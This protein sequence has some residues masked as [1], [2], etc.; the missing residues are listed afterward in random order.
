MQD[1]LAQVYDVGIAKRRL[2]A[3]LI[4]WLG[5]SRRSS[6]KSGADFQQACITR[7]RRLLCNRQPAAGNTSIPVASSWRINAKIGWWL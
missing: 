1:E 5:N 6:E 2:D 7:L 3:Y 4:Q